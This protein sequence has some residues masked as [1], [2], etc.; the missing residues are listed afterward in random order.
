MLTVKYKFLGD[1]S[2]SSPPLNYAPGIDLMFWCVLLVQKFLNNPVV[3]LP[4]SV[5][6]GTATTQLHWKWQ[7]YRI[8]EDRDNKSNVAKLCLNQ[9]SHILPPFLD[10]HKL[11]KL[12]T[13]KWINK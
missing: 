8:N 9:C 6:L 5:L 3:P 1:L 7:H 10:E 11:H 13:C 12:Q 4:L 2:P